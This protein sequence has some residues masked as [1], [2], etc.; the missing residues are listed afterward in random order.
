MPRGLN[1]QDSFPSNN[2]DVFLLCKSTSCMLY[3]RK[4]YNCNFSPDYVLKVT[5]RNL[6]VFAVQ[7]NVLIMFSC[8]EAVSFG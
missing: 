8:E 6:I 3:S 5:E 4:F 1:L 2:I 7:F